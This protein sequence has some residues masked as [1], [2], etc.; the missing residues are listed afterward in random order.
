MT[1]LAK[2][3]A[4]I[5]VFAAGYAILMLIN[6]QPTDFDV[7]AGICTVALLKAA[8]FEYR[9]SRKTRNE[10]VYIAQ[11]DSLMPKL[12]AGRPT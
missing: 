9:L 11:P 5:A 4:L 2:A 7:S 3:S 6:G 8:V 12:A 1:R 10:H